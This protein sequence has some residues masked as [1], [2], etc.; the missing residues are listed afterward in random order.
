MAD[1]YGMLK[2]AIRDDDPVLFCENLVLYNVTGSLPDDRRGHWCRSG[3]AAVVRE[4]EDLTIVAHSYTVQRALRVA[5]RLSRDG[6]EAEVVDLRSLR[7]LDAETVAESVRK[8][9]RALVAEEGWATYGVGAELVAARSTACASTISTLRSSGSARPRCRCH[10][11]S[12]SSWPRCRSRRRS[13]P[14]HGASSRNAG[15]SE[16]V[17]EELVMPRLSD[18]ME[19]GTIGRWLVKR[20]RLLQRGRR[21]RRDR[22]RQGD[23]GAP[24]LRR[25][26]VLRILV[27]DGETADLGAPIAIVGD[28]GEEVAATDGKAEK[29]PEAAA[30]EPQEQPEP[31]SQARQA[32]E[33][34]AQAEPVPNGK[35]AAGTTLKVSPIARKMADQAGIDLRAA[36]RARQRPGGPD[37]QGRRGAADRRRWGRRTARPGTGRTPAGD[38]RS[39]RSRGQAG[40]RGRGA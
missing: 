26:H 6:V 11:P 32:A 10:T 28:A 25:R 37:R 14:P 34:P 19:Q 22:D 9:N 36:G 2:T 13:R 20:R 15:C 31:A 29:Q 39:G 7:P 1:A 40:R 18:T 33:Q 5:D 4:G 17:S 21:A 23:D 30:D 3:E 24:G 27:D 12:R 38:G 35:P 8:T 16:G